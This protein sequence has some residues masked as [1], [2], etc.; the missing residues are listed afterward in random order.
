MPAAAE[1]TCL[2]LG[3]VTNQPWFYVTMEWLLVPIII[4]VTLIYRNW[5]TSIRFDGS[6]ISIGA[7]GSVRAPARAE[8]D[9]GR[10]DP[11][12]RSS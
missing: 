2:I 11:P 8:P 12:S 9:M 4:W 5:P 6:A 10:A 3:V 1:I 7:V